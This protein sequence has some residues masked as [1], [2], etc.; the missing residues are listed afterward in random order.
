MKIDPSYK[1]REG[2]GATFFRKWEAMVK[3]FTEQDGSL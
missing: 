3:W 2:E 1:D